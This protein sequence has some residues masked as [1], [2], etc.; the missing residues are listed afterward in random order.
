MVLGIRYQQSYEFIATHGVPL[1]HYRDH[2]PARTFDPRLF[3]RE[4]EVSDLQREHAFVALTVVPVAGQWRYGANVP[5]RM[6]MSLEDGG[7]LALSCAD[8]KVREKDGR[9]LS[10]LRGYAEMISDFI[11]LSS[12]V[13]SAAKS[14]DSVGVIRTVLQAGLARLNMQ[15]CITDSS[16]QIIG[17]SKQ[18]GQRV[19]QIDGTQL[20]V[21]QR[22]TGNWFSS[23][24]QAAAM[25]C[26]ET[27]QP[28]QWLAV[29]DSNHRMQL[30]DI[31][32]IS[33]GDLGVFGVFALHEGEHAMAALSERLG[34]RQ[35]H[36]AT[37]SSNW[38]GDGSGPLSTFLA[39]TLLVAQRLYRSGTTNYIGLRK[40]RTPIKPYQI[41]ALR[42]LKADL[43]ESFVDQVAKEMA[44]AIIS[45]YGDVAN[46][47]VVPMPC[48]NSG[49]GCFSYRLGRKVAKL[50]SVAVVDALNPISD[51]TGSSHPKAN[52]KRA[53]MT[54]AEAVNQTV[55]L[56]EDVVTSGNH[57]DEAA[58]LLRKSSSQVWPVAWIVS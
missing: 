41:S 35:L 48:G 1:S 43:P 10:I 20:K 2:V 51:C 17:F 38:G 57:I 54:V 47:V 36:D 5:V 21:G 45:I 11:W 39:E 37:P 26:F 13:E 53:K 24:L 52:L 22:I 29:D 4:I 15:V 23:D 58:R 6:Q 33:F 56:I 31:Y 12:Q 32:P 49:P 40:W 28:R 3:A 9:I 50:L 34:E 8:T 30:M 46:C 42:A 55:I 19:K 18:F 44:D 7:V 25:G 16:L 14:F 27:E